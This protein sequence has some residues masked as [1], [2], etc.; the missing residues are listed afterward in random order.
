MLDVPARL[1]IA[2][3]I[4][5]LF[6]KYLIKECI[7]LQKKFSF[8]KWTDPAD[9]HITLK[10]LGDTTLDQIQQIHKYLNDLS[11]ATSPFEL[12]NLGWGV[13]GPQTAPAILWA[14]IGG[15]VNSLHNLQQKV[16]GS[17][18]NIGFIQEARAFHPHIT[19]ARRY[20][21]KIPLGMLPMQYLPKTSEPSIHW[22]VNEIKLYQSHLQKKPMYEEIASFKLGY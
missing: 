19:I 12:C 4:D 15:E 10:F 21:G 20:K 18:I 7:M 5:E 14:G 13:F 6:R 16:D 8:Q 17:L 2:V 1:F 11:S 22:Q 9:Y 3:P